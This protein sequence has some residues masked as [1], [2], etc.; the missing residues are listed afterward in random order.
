[1]RSAQVR[2]SLLADIKVKLE[3][4]Y[5]I[6]I[7]FA[8]LIIYRVLPRHQYLCLQLC[9]NNLG[10]LLSRE[11]LG[12]LDRSTNSSVDDQLRQDTNGTGNTEE[13]GVVAGFGQTVVLEQDTGVLKMS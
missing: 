13:D 11:R 6:K 2:C 10:P 1:M 12:S 5:A 9:A 3:K 4:W 7:N 8:S